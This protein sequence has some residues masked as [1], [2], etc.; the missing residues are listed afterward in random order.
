MVQLKKIGTY[1]S[2]RGSVPT[3][4]P[5]NSYLIHKPIQH[6]I[7]LPKNDLP[8]LHYGQ[9]IYLYNN[10]VTNQVVYSLSRHLNVCNPSITA[11]LQS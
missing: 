2:R 10:L 8:S 4:L 7:P 9:H 11:N 1:G 5:P 6:G 3:Q